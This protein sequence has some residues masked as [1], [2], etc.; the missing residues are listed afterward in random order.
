MQKLFKIK[1]LKWVEKDGTWKA[2]TPAGNY[3]VTKTNVGW[4]WYSDLPGYRGGEA[5]S[6]AHG[7]ELAEADWQSRISPA[8]EEVGNEADCVTKPE[9]GPSLTALILAY[10]AGYRHGHGS[11]V[12]GYY[13][14]VAAS[15]EGSYFLEDV[16]AMVADGSLPPAQPEPD[17]ELLKVLQRVAIYRDRLPGNLEDMVYEA[18]TKAERRMKP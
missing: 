4:R 16:A 3:F 9:P 10:T 15:D 8:L 18:V 1:P 13:A 11:T 12:D 6:L 17:R 7:K 5:D 2:V 14:D